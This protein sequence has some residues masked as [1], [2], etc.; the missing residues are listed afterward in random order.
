MV[1]RWIWQRVSEA[2]N[3]QELEAVMAEVLASLGS[4]DV[5]IEISVSPQQ[6]A[7]IMQLGWLAG[8]YKE[9]SPVNAQ[10]FLDRALQVYEQYLKELVLRRR[11]TEAS[12]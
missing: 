4:N 7:R 3:R 9:I 8:R 1:A 11:A 6:Y 5:R 10:Q 12:T 2:K